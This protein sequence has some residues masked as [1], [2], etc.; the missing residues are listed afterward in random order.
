MWFL[1]INFFF[2]HDL[3]GSISCRAK[4]FFCWR[5]MGCLSLLVCPQSEKKIAPG[6]ECW[7]TVW[8]AVRLFCNIL[9]PHDS[10]SF[11]CCQCWFTDW[12]CYSSFL[13]NG[14]IGHSQS[15]FLSLVRFPTSRSRGEK[16][17]SK[18]KVK[19]RKLRKVYNFV[20]QSEKSETSEPK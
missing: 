15:P 2:A 11:V 6:R 9:V 17:I 10:Y 4:L 1:K 20:C 3:A 12:R 5:W 8:W 14:E 18:T 13:S 16:G 19:S 7:I